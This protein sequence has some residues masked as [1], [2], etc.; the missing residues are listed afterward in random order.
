MCGWLYVEGVAGICW[1]LRAMSMIECSN[2]LAKCVAGYML[3]VLR[4]EGGWNP[5]TW[6]E[7]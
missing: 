6:L 1:V 5:L 3:R 2:R 4:V 7:L